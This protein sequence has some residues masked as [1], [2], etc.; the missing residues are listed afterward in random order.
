MQSTHTRC[1]N[2]L[3]NRKSQLSEWVS[4]SP[5][6][7]ERFLSLSLFPLR[8]WREISVAEFF[9]PLLVAVIFSGCQR[10]SITT[11]TT[12][13]L[14]CFCFFFFSCT[15]LSGFTVW[16]KLPV[17]K[18]VF[19]VGRESE[20]DR[21]SSLVATSRKCAILLLVVVIG[22]CRYQLQQQKQQI[23]PADL[24]SDLIRVRWPTEM[25]QQPLSQ[26]VNTHHQPSQCTSSI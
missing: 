23:R 3:S 10:L 17:V 22:R 1:Q 8:L 26:F 16:A 24:F 18:K 12:V 9:L 5:S 21:R 13:D 15:F 19:G 14:I 25:Q 20:I 4:L 6:R 11:T 2:S 7:I